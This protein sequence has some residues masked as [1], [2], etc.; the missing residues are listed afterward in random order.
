[1]SSKKP[2][3]RSDT[4]ASRPAADPA[5]SGPDELDSASERR[6]NG[7]FDRLAD[8]I[9]AMDRRFEAM[10]RKFDA[11]QGEI[12][13]LRARTS[14]P[15]SPLLAVAKPASVV[16]SKRRSLAVTSADAFGSAPASASAE[17]TPAAPP[18]NITTKAAKFGS[19]ETVAMP[20]VNYIA[21]FVTEY[22]YFKANPYTPY[23]LS[24]PSSLKASHTAQ[25]D[26]QQAQAASFHGR[27]DP[28]LHLKL[29]DLQVQ[30]RRSHVNLHDW[31]SFAA[32]ACGETHEDIREWAQE[33]R[34]KWH[35]F[36]LA[37]IRENGLHH[38]HQRRD[39]AFAHFTF[40][41]GTSSERTINDIC[42]ELRFAPGTHKATDH[43]AREFEA[44]LFRLDLA[45]E[46]LVPS[47]I[48]DG[49]RKKLSDWAKSATYIAEKHWAGFRTSQ[50]AAQR[51]AQANLVP[52]LD[53]PVTTSTQTNS[54]VAVNDADAYY[55]SEIFR[56]ETKRGRSESRRGGTTPARPANQSS[57]RPMPITNRTV[58]ITRGT[59]YNVRDD[60]GAHVYEEDDARSAAEDDSCS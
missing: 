56:I 8:M 2:T 28:D 16:D 14:P 47:F 17:A 1:M 26:Q 40:V 27:R 9:A 15:P 44:H 19:F 22:T 58:K 7:T 24:N 10:D 43:R 57:L 54:G 37:I 13:E 41:P 30:L 34:S 51:E 55:A 5:D 3:T 35:H 36:V 31:P 52:G 45:L 42:A 23:S 59:L 53:S 20:E 33:Y 49:S 25:L 4:L 6:S 50:I 18:D 46:G 12:N 21:K 29:R 11:L 32:D 39:S 48:P 38:Y 60:N